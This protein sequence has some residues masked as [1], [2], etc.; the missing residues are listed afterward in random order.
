MVRLQKYLA[1]CGVASRRKSE[2]LISAGL[3]KVNGKPVTEL[4]TKIDESCDIIEYGGK[5]IKHAEDEKIYIMLHKPEGCV[6]TAKDQFNR[7]T[8]MDMLSDIDSRVY[9][10]GRLDYNTSGLLLLT[11]DGDLAYTLTHPKHNIDKVYIAKLAGTPTEDEMERFRAGLELSD[12]LT[13]PAEIE[14]IKQDEH[15]S[16]VKISIREG[17]NRQVRR[18]CDAIGYKTAALKR[19]A[20]GKIFLG[21]LERGKYRHLT[22]SEINYLKNLER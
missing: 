6:T 2:E 1:D 12:G 19:I 11:N 21:K 14:I 15:F 22:D 7:P 5:V 16:S 4:G 10:V 9:P 18:M 3:V 20:T 17:K 13:A 8:V